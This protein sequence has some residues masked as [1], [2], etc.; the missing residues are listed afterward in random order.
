[1]GLTVILS[2]VSSTAGARGRRSAGAQQSEGDSVRKRFLAVAGLL[3]LL[4]SIIPAAAPVFADSGPDYD[5]PNGHFY[6]QTNGGAGGNGFAITDD[7]GVPMWTWFQKYGGVS[8]L[9]YP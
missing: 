1:M 8:L 6:T 7:G 4:L 9:G 2:A 5:I 3:A